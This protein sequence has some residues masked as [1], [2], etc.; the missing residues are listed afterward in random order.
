MMM[1]KSKLKICANAHSLRRIGETVGDDA[2]DQPLDGV[3][4]RDGAEVIH[5]VWALSRVLD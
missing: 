3:K 5:G 4:E 2:T 1:A